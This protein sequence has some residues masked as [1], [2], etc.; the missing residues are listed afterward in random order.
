MRRTQRF[1]FSLSPVEETRL[2]RVAEQMGT[3]AADVLRLG[4]F[5]V[6][7]KATAAPTPE[8]EP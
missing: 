7:D 4:I 1:E 2:W 6:A 5:L 8:R 3:S